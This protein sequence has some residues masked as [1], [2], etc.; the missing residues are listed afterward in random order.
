MVCFKLCFWFLEKTGIIEESRA[1]YRP[2]ELKLE[3]D[4]SVTSAEFLKGKQT[5]GTYRLNRR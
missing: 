5:E 3:D 4:F 2:I 1:K